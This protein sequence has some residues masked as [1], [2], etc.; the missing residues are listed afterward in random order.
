[1]KKDNLSL[2]ENMTESKYEI[3]LET[4]RIGSISRAAEQLNY[5]QSGLTYTLNAIEGD[6]GISV[7]NRSHKGVSLTDDGKQL[8]PY[9]RAVID[10]EKSLRN[11]IRELVSSDTGRIRIGAIQSIAK[12]CLPQIIMEFKTLYPNADISF[13]VCGG[14]EI[15]SLVQNK[16]IDIGIVDIAVAGDLDCVML[17]DEEVYIAYPKEW[18]LPT[19]DGAVSLDTLYEYPML[20]MANPNNAGVL[21]MKNKPVQHK[22]MVS[23]DGDT[24]L[25]MV[26]AG[27]GFS[28]LSKRFEENCPQGVCMCPAEPPIIRTIGVIANSMKELHPLTKKFVRQLQET[29]IM[30]M[31]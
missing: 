25:S 19:Q 11:K 16:E 8:E 12:Y 28:M 21:V 9:L 22:I 3:L 10:S 23:S 31:E 26:D 24:I 18:E 30:E 29:E 5:T 2:E 7:L 15:P 14:M 6:L 13:R 17:Q 4:L 1:M 20:Y 27:M